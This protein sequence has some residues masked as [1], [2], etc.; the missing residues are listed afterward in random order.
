[1]ATVDTLTESQLN[2]L[3]DLADLASKVKQLL[4]GPL[5]NVV[6]GYVV[7]GTSLVPDG[8]LDAVRQLMET[9]ARWRETGVLDQIIALME[10]LVSLTAPERMQPIID[11]SL[12]FLQ[13]GVVREV[14]AAVKEMRETQSTRQ[15]GGLGAMMRMMRDPDVQAGLLVMARMAGAV[16]SSLRK[17]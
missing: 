15:L 10:G 17:Q 7:Q 13:S 6:A 1:M 9:L 4:D 3:A 16:G 5:G 12:G 2:G 11:E 8:A 14:A